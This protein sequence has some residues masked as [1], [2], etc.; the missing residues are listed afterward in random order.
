MIYK[1]AYKTPEK[2]SDVIMNSDGEYLTGLW[3]VNSRDTSKQV[4]NCE[5]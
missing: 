3:F 2:F 1:Y 4:V 5:V